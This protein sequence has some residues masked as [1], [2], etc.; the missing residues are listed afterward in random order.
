[1]DKPV[2]EAHTGKPR[3]SWLS[4]TSL[5]AMAQRHSRVAS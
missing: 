1:M 4:R 3:L 2:I 5:L